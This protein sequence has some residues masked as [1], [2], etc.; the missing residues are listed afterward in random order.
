M[1]YF[2][3]EQR[4]A[5]SLGLRFLVGLR[6]VFFLA[7]LLRFQKFLKYIIVEICFFLV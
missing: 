6:V 5:S 3:L 1:L 4:R 2:V 7:V